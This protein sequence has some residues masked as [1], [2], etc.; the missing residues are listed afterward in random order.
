MSEYV[1][2]SVESYIHILLLLLV[3][4]YEN[5]DGN[6]RQEYKEEYFS[7]AF[8]LTFLFIFL[9][10]FIYF[11]NSKCVLN[12]R[13]PSDFD[14]LDQVKVLNIYYIYKMILQR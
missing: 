3:D 8:F 9:I 5:M 4:D 14:L 2:C 1:E 7:F 12:Y 10:Y 13:S 11:E 6:F